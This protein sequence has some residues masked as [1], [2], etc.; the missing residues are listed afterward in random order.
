MAREATLDATRR[1]TLRDLR[2]NVSRMC[3]FYAGG[4]RRVRPVQPSRSS[5]RSG[6]RTQHIMQGLND[7]CIIPGVMPDAIRDLGVPSASAGP[8]NC[9]RRGVL[10]KS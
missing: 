7:Q 3:P 10:D 6:L 5:S 2:F 9:T 8:R 4:S 1:H